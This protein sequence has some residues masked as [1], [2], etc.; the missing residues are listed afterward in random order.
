MKKIISILSIFLIAAI[1]MPASAAEAF[2]SEAQMNYSDSSVTVSGNIGRGGECVL[3]T[4]ENP[5]GDIKIQH[6]RSV[7]TSDDGSF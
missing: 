7:I 3:I 1:A 5:T 6:R 2:S 4:D